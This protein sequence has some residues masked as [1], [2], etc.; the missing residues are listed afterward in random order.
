M[1]PWWC[2][3]WPFSL[4]PWITKI[5]IYP[6]EHAVWEINCCFK[7]FRS[8]GCFLPPYPSLSWF[9]HLLHDYNRPLTNV[10]LPLLL[11]HCIFK[12]GTRVTL[13]KSSF[14][15][16]DDNLQRF[17]FASKYFKFSNITLKAYHEIRLYRYSL[18]SIKIMLTC[19]YTIVF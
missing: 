11:S 7:L 1:F 12:T 17:L 2:L 5:R 18:Q 9:Q 19:P 13:V 6:D 4:Y 8:E 15:F 10:S 3:C 14:H 16:S